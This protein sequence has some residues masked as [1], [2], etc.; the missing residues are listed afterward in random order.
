MKTASYQ[1]DLIERLR[2]TEYA[3]KL[4]CHSFDESCRDGNWKAFGLILQDVI[5]AQGSIHAFA[6]RAGISRPHL[7]KIFGRSA[8]P[9]LKTLLPILETLGLTLALS[10][11]PQISKA[12]KRSK[13]NLKRKKAA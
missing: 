9:T 7:Y 12:S 10:R 1:E 6:Q 3:K 5:S 4:L 11:K 8:N 13:E 2:S